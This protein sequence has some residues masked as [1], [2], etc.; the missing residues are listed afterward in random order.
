MMNIESGYA[1]L[2]VGMGSGPGILVNDGFGFIHL[3]ILSE[4]IGRRAA[5]SANGCAEMG[6]DA[7]VKHFEAI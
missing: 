3:I 4:K 7:V 1:S 2:K 6:F 5:V